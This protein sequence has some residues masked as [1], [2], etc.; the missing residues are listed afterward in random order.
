MRDMTM[1]QI[2]SRN[3]KLLAYWAVSLA[4][5]VLGLVTTPSVVK[6]VCAYGDCDGPYPFTCDPDWCADPQL[7]QTYWDPSCEMGETCY[8]YIC[9]YDIKMGTCYYAYSCDSEDAWL[10]YQLG[11]H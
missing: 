4:M 3:R 1:R 11:V 5:S 6:A 10:C 2:L 7:M 9:W 8:N